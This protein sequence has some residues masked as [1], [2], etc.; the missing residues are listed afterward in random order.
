MG[1]RIHDDQCAGVP[2]SVCLAT[3]KLETL[4]LE[5]GFHQPARTR[6]ARDAMKPFLTALFLTTLLAVAQEP[7]PS[8]SPTRMERLVWTA[9]LP[10]GEYNVRVS[11]INS[12][13][14]H[15]YVVDNAARVTEVNVGTAGAE[16]VR[17]YCIEPNV[18]KAPGGVGQS[19]LTKA[20]ET[21][22]EILNRTRMDETWQ[23][24]MKNYPTTTHAHTIEYRIPDRKTLQ[25]L[26][27]HLKDSWVRQRGAVFKP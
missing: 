24:V 9:S 13:S 4:G 7:T 22:N 3:E 23:K 6:I 27:D 12:V 16:M 14:L 2:L 26:F 15:E 18:P 19:V 17:F 20:E 10:G 21:A 25:A 1:R 8:P 11:A 5:A